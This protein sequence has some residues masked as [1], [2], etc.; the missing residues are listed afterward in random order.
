MMEKLREFIDERFPWE[1]ME[2]GFSDEE[3]ITEAVLIVRVLKTDESNVH[4][5]M[6]ERTRC[7]MSIGCGIIMTKGMLTDTQEQLAFDAADNHLGGDD[8]GTSG[9]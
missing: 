7:F 9:V 1:D 8:D 3:L 4:G 2:A 6:P 5:E